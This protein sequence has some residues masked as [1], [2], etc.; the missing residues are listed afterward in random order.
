MLLKEL[1]RLCAK[2]GDINRVIDLLD[3]GVN[4]ESRDQVRLLVQSSK[5]PLT[6]GIVQF[7]YSA[8]LLAVNNGRYEIAKVFCERGASVNDKDNVRPW[9]ALYSSV[10]CVLYQAGN[11][12]LMLACRWN[13]PDIVN[14]LL[15]SGAIINAKNEVIKFASC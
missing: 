2:Q 6:A 7:G 3:G 12:A 4:I 13:K 1:L 14:L 15:E 5:L 10:L 11:T 9:I 8:F